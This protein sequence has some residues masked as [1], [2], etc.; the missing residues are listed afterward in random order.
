MAKQETAGRT[1]E[2][3]ERGRSAD[4]PSEIPAKGWKDVLLRARAEMKD[5]HAS[6]IA[7]GVA[8][9][10]LLAIFPA[11]AAM[12]SI[13]ALASSPQEM[14]AQLEGLRAAL[15]PA[16]SDIL[17]QQASTV[18]GG[19]ET[20]HGVT[21]LVGILFAL[22]S[23]SKG[24][25]SLIEG[26]NIAYDE[27]DERG[28]IKSNL[29]AIGL[30]LLAVSAMLVGLAAIAALPILLEALQLGEPWGML[31]ALLPWPILFVGGALVLSVIYRFA[32][33]RD[34]ARWRWITWGAAIAMAVWIA[35][36]IG[37]SIYVA[38]FGDYNAT[39]GALGG[40]IVLL[41]WLWLSALAV[42]A[43]AEINAELERQTKRDSTQGAPKP[44]G[45]RRARAAD[46]LGEAKA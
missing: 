35:G 4:K 5:D 17:I 33:D 45:A 31:A 23:A 14:I 2:T 25:K 9:Y 28:F 19:E 44:M 42:M 24:M 34:P 11:I 38:N 43:G 29:T 8:F 3:G 30:T 12:V 18:A 7:A 40:V 15:P 26:I 27:T 32:P 10:G 39:Y 20:G 37:F 36:S 16:A 1:R 6:L 22:W 41:L 21:A 46:T 13:W